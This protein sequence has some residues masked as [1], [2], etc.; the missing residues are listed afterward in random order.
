MIVGSGEGIFG[1][2]G[3][4]TFGRQQQ[5]KTADDPATTSDRRRQD[6]I[7]GD[8]ASCP[9]CP[10]RRDDSRRRRDCRGDDRRRQRRDT[11]PPG[12]GDHLAIMRAVKDAPKTIGRSPA[13]IAAENDVAAAARLRHLLLAHGYLPGCCGGRPA[14]PPVGDDVIGDVT[15]DIRSFS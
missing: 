11:L 10:R 5:D 13:A 1:E 15:A 2:P 14:A 3:R 6:A 12:G 9:L 4:A 8:F 7:A